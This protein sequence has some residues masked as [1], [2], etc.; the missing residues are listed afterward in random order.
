[1][2]CELAHTQRP[3]TWK[4]GSLGFAT[5]N[6]HLATRPWECTSPCGVWFAHPVS[7]GGKTTRQGRGGLDAM[8]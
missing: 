8:I 4:S 6:G 2:S 5:L 7:V 3:H 1:M